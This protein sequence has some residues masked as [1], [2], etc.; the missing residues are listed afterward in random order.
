MAAPTS[1]RNRRQQTRRPR[2]ARILRIG[3]LLGGKIVEERLIRERTRVS[4]GQSMKNT[5][6]IPVEGLPLESRCSSLDQNE[7]L[8]ALPAGMDGRLS[9]GGNVYD[10]RPL[11]QRRAATAAATG[12]SRCR[13]SRAASC[14]SA[15]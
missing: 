7:V 13:D 5:F 11:K 9:D 2:R 14:R 4:V 6:S 12:R 1:D 15:T 8:P 3:I 10:A